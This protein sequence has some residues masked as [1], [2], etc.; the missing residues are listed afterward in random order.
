MIIADRDI[1]SSGYRIYSTIDKE[2][3]DAMNEAARNF[4]YYGHTYTE[5]S[6]E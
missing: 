1:R 6:D 3:Y 5:T 4:K 2:M